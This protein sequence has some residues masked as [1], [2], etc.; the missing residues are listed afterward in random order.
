MLSDRWSANVS[1]YISQEMPLRPDV[2]NV[3][4][5]P[6]FVLRFQRHA[7]LFG[8]RL[9]SQQTRL[10]SRSQIGDDGIAPHAHECAPVKVQRSDPAAFRLLQT[11]GRDHHVEMCIEI[12]VSP[13]RVGHRHNEYAGTVSGFHPLLDHRR[14]KGGQVVEELA[15]LPKDW[16]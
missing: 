6:A 14:R 9:R 16:P 5:P 12:Q 15:V 4:V 11:A 10:Q 8:T 13:K 3:N 1:R 7:E 2:I